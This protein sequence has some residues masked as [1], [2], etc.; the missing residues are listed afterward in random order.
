MNPD[1]FPC[2]RCGW[3]RPDCTC[4]TPPAAQ[5]IPKPTPNASR[6]ASHLPAPPVHVRVPADPAGRGWAAA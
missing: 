4:K 6:V 3:M 1:L 5:R 2:Q